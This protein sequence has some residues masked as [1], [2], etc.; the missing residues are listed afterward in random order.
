MP[1]VFCRESP[2][3]APDGPVDVVKAEVVRMGNG[4]EGLLLNKSWPLSVG[5]SALAA[6]SCKPFGVSGVGAGRL[7]LAFGVCHGSSG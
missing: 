1:V 7:A 4:L 2:A 5:L 6:F 3:P